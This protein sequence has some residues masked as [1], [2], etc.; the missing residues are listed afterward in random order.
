MIQ[1]AMQNIITSSIKF[2]KEYG[3][4]KISA[5]NYGDYAEI[6]ISDDGIG[7]SEESIENLFRVDVRHTTL[8]T[9]NEKG[10]GLGLIISKELISK[11]NG[12]IKVESEPAK[13][14]KLMFTLPLAN[15]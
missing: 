3:S 13:G 8:G 15:N 7:L 6:E 1:T 9:A 5:T 11:N 10:S 14:T 12:T 4:I 2:S